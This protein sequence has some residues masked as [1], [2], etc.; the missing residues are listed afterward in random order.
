VDARDGEAWSFGGQGGTVPLNQVS[1]EHLNFKEKPTL[2]FFTV[3]DC[4]RKFAVFFNPESS[5]LRTLG[6]LVY[7]I[8]TSLTLLAMTIID[9]LYVIARRSCG[10]PVHLINPM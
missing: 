1:L 8:A 10:N 4:R 3:L 6:V 9:T 5:E 2:L 7:W